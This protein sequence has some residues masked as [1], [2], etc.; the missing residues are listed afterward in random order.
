MA[1]LST[2]NMA[3]SSNGDAR[4]ATVMPSK[5]AAR[6]PVALCPRASITW[7]CRIW[8][9]SRAV[10]VRPSTRPGVQYNPIRGM[11]AGMDEK[12]TNASASAC[13][14]LKPG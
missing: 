9:P 1:S 14:V 10:R 13:D 4:V 2:G 6:H 7:P 8:M 5:V 11:P 12:A 3:T